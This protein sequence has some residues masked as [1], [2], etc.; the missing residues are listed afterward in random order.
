M[1]LSAS[2]LSGSPLGR[3]PLGRWPAIAICDPAFPRCP[4]PLNQ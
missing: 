4:D 1:K 3:G 2:P